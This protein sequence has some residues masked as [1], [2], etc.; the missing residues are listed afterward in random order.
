MLMC[1]LVAGLVAWVGQLLPLRLGLVGAVVGGV[2]AGVFTDQLS[3]QQ[4]SKA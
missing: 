4:G 1:L 3:H 2:L